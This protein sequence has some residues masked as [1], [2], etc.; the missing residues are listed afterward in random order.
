MNTFENHGKSLK[1]HRKTFE[2]HRKSLKNHENAFEK[3]TIEKP[4]KTMENL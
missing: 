3:Q 2:N 1:N 4:L